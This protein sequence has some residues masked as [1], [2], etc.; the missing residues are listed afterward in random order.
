MIAYLFKYLKMPILFVVPYM[1]IIT[2]TDILLRFINY[3]FFKSNAHFEVLFY[4]TENDFFKSSLENVA[5]SVYDILGSC[6]PEFFANQY[7]EITGNISSSLLFNIGFF[8]ILYATIAFSIFPIL[9]NFNFFN[10]FI[11]K[12]D[13]EHNPYDFKKKYLKEIENDYFRQIAFM[14]DLGRLGLEIKLFLTDYFTY[15]VLQFSILLSISLLFI[16]YISHEIVFDMGKYVCLVFI[17]F[18]YD[19]Y[20]F[21]FK[22]FIILEFIG[23]SI[24]AALFLS[25][26]FFHNNFLVRLIHVHIVKYFV[27]LYY[28]NS[29]FLSKR[30]AVKR[31]KKFNN[32]RLYKCFRLKV[33]EFKSKK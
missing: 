33:R 13:P 8:Y 27:A 31:I 29:S 14:K 12:Y 17:I 25:I 26:I 15:Q 30:Y 11:K 9:I 23:L 3:N 16:P 24:M 28:Y 21:F 6:I 19:V 4:R 32:K 2:L 20:L 7:V 1:L 22:F 10:E 5:K 18:G